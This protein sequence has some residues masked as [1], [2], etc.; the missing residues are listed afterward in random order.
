MDKKKKAAAMAAVFA[1]IKSSEEVYAMQMAAEAEADAA[2]QMAAPA[3]GPG[4]ANVWGMAGR[5][6]IM[7]ASTMMQLRVF[8]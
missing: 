1:H 2:A 8:K 6:E 4:L 7:Q 3:Q 5:Q